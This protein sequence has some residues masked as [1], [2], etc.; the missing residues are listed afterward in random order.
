MRCII[1]FLKEIHNKGKDYKL[2]YG[3]ISLNKKKKEIYLTNQ[4]FK[5][6]NDIN[7][8]IFDNKLEIDEKTNKTK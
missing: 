5:H 3:I 7:N 6:Y 1:Y 4:Q 2:C 8:I